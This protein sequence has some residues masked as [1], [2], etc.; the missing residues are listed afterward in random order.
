MVREFKKFKLPG[1]D[2]ATTRDRNTK[3]LEKVRTPIKPVS[4]YSARGRIGSVVASLL[5][6]F[7]AGGQR[8][9]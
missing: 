9:M 6:A 7:A 1:K 2:G 4:T 5:L 3:P 8:R